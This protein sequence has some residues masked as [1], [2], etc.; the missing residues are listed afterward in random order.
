MIKVLDKEKNYVIVKMDIDTFDHIKTR[1]PSIQELAIEARNSDKTY[2]SMDELF[3][4]L[5][6]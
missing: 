1:N 6:N 2:Y 5:E 4:D 3:Y